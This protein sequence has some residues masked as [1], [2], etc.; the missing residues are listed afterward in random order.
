MKIGKNLKHMKINALLS[1]QWVSELTRN[2]FCPQT[3]LHENTTQQNHN[4]TT[5]TYQRLQQYNKLLHASSK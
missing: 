5:D 1:N 4:K 3:K 2:L